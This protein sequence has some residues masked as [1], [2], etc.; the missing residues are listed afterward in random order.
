ML[1][2]RLII[3]RDLIALGQVGVE[4]VFARKARITPDFAVQ[5]QRRLDGLGHHLA[6]ENRQGPRQAQAYRTGLRVGRSAEV[7]RAA[8]EDLSPSEQLDMDFQANDG[9]VF[10]DRFRA[11]EANLDHLHRASLVSI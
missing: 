10:G 8:A 4:V 2:Q 7:G 5:R 6:V 9:L 1:G 3:L 11:G